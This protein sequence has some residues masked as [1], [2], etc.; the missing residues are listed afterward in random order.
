MRIVGP[1]LAE[2]L[3]Y[4]RL[5]LR[6]DPDA[7]V[8]DR[9]LYRTVC[10]PGLNSNPSFLRGELHCVGKQIEK[11]LF[12]LALIADE[13]A[14][15]LVNGNVKIDAVLGGSLTHKGAR[16]I[17]CQ[18]EIKRSQLQLHPPSLHLGKVEDLID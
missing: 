14:K 9:N 17:D 11:N 2:F 5:I 16:V 1:H 3:E 13:V 12:D 4:L 15:T 8:T 7:G 18:G 6:G 10:L